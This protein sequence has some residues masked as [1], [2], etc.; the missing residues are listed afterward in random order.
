MTLGW[1]AVDI[2]TSEGGIAKVYKTITSYEQV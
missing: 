2:E 1:D